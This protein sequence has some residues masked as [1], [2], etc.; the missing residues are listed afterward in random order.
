M[1]AGVGV[2]GAGA[3][4][5]ELGVVVAAGAGVVADVGLIPESPPPQAARLHAATAANKW[6][7][8]CVFMEIPRD[9]TSQES[10]ER[11]QGTPPPD[12]GGTQVQGP[13]MR[14]SASHPL[15]KPTWK[16]GHPSIQFQHQQLSLQGG[17]VDACSCLQRI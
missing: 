7:N 3:G 17:S 9:E 4:A 12:Q 10:I 11:A 14:L 2:A 1:G 15:K 5:G 6:V 16:S 13:K 8:V